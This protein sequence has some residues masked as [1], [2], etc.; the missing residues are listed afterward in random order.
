VDQ[1]CYQALVKLPLVRE[2]EEAFRKATGVPLKLVPAGVP[3]ARSSLGRG[4]N[5]FCALVS[6]T[7]QGQMVC[8]K[9]EAAVQRRVSEELSPHSVYCFAGLHLVA[10]PVIVGGRHLATWMS[11]QVLCKP[12]SDSSFARVARQ[13]AKMGI[14]VGTRNLKAAYCASRVVTKEQLEAM[15]RLLI[16]LA[17]H[18]AEQASRA[19]L[20]GQD[21][22]PVCVTRAKGFV[23]AHLSERLSLRQVAA[24]VHLSPYHFCRRFGKATGMTLTEYVSRLRVERAQT[25]LA[26]PFVRVSDVAFAAGFGSIPQFNEVF[27][28]HTGMSPTKYRASLRQRFQI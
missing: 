1:S 21:A 23:K 9:V 7:Q 13:L 27:R 22:G 15:R 24:E 2:C 28:K 5:R 14:K 3:A 4:E 12:P 19:M 10:V 18:L 25:L 8:W 16:Q 26:D 11:G 17:D 6:G 20:A